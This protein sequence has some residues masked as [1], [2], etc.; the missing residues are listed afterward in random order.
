MTKAALMSG[1]AMFKARHSN[2]GQK[3]SRYQGFFNLATIAILEQIIYLLQEA[4]MPIAGC[5]E[6]F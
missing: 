4:V 6:A 1:E 3:S 5:L 2:S